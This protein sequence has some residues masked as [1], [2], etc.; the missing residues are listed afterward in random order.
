MRYLLILLCLGCGTSYNKA[1]IH[2]ALLPYVQLFLDEAKKRE[3]DVEV[4]Y[5]IGF[6]DSFPDHVY[7][8]CIQLSDKT[9]IEINLDKW[10]DLSELSKEQLM[11]HELGHC[12]LNREHDS[13]MLSSNVPKS[14]MHPFI[15]NDQMYANYKDYYLRELFSR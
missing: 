6:N 3:I 4:D 7:G 11:L 5:F 8:K 1:D 13:S 10:D 2:P 14:I 9:T 15:M 12:S